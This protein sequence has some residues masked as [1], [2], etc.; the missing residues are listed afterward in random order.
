VLALQR[1]AGRGCALGVL[2]LEEEGHGRD[3]LQVAAGAPLLAVTQPA[4][5][6]VAPLD[7]QVEL[8][9]EQVQVAHV[10]VEGHQPADMAD[11]LEAL[12]GYR[13]RR[14]RLGVAA[15]EDERQA[16]VGVTERTGQDL[17][18]LLRHRGAQLQVGDRLAEFALRREPARRHQRCNPD[19]HPD[20][21][22]TAVSA[23]Q[24]RMEGKRSAGRQ[25]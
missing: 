15:R 21:K 11:G 25:R 10:D 17:S 7:G 22:L 9:A 2:L 16:Q 13:P 12:C 18:V 19:H 8:S 1:P 23:A 20:S 4:Q 14:R 5:P 6:L 3:D 24:N